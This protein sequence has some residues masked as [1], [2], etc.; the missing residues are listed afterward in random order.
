MAARA[1]RVVVLSGAG[2]SAES[3]LLTFRDAGGLWEG[4][5]VEEVATP[6]AFARNPQLVLDFYN[7]RRAQLQHVHPNAAHLALVDLEQAYDVHIITQNVDDLHER[8]GSTQVLHLHGELTKV[9][10]TVNEAHV[11]SW[12]GDQHLDDRDPQGYPM[13]P[14]IVWFGE[15]VPMIETAVNIIAHADVVLVVGTSMQ[16]YP[17]ASL[18]DYA[19]L[20]IPVYYIDPAAKALDAQVHIR[21]EVASVGV[22]AVVQELLAAAS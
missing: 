19:P 14:F 17:A 13:R 4:H 20:D 5:K 22:P 1:Q 7:Q 16:V 8:A 18:L 21:A 3:G 12:E 15:A 10:S 9:R 11:I 2:I 6:E